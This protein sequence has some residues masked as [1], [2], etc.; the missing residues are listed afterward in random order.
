MH[1]FFCHRNAHILINLSQSVYIHT[2]YM[3]LHVVLD[4]GCVREYIVTQRSYYM[5]SSIYL[6]TTTDSFRS[7]Q[8]KK[9]MYASV[10]CT[11]R[12]LDIN[13]LSTF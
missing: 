10:L 8:F 4:Q 6:E 9:D 1:V 12:R 3:L 5:S 2:E 13:P 7:V 11:Q